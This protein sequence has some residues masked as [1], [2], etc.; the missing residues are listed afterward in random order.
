METERAEPVANKLPKVYRS[1][2]IGLGSGQ[3]KK[4]ALVV[5]PASGHYPKSPE[6]KKSFAKE[7]LRA[8]HELDRLRPIKRIFFE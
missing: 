5:E 4:P 7:V 6:E 3:T 2:L 1:A 8:L